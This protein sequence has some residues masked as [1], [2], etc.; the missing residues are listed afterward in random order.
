MTYSYDRRAD[1]VSEALRHLTKSQ[2]DDLS[3]EERASVAQRVIWLRKN[4][5]VQQAKGKN[6][7]AAR[8]FNN[9]KNPFMIYFLVPNYRGEMKVYGWTGDGL[10]LL[11]RTDEPTF[12]T[13]A[14]AEKII[15]TK[16]VPEIK[17]YH[18]GDDVF[19]LGW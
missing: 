7:Y 15:K 13:E 14:E 12:Q 6:P 4:H 1:A 17:R 3:P 11:G 8:P 16:V 5:G 9:P 2:L 10:A 18:P 19:I